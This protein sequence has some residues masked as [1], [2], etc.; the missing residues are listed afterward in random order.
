MDSVA[1]A[2]VLLTAWDSSMSQAR[3]DRESIWHE[4]EVDCRAE[5]V[6]FMASERSHR[7]EDTM[8][9][10]KRLQWRIEDME[11]RNLENAR[12]L[13]LRFVE[14]NRRDVE[15]KTEQLKAISNLAAL[16][17]GFAVVTLT[18]FAIDDSTNSADYS[19]WNEPST[20]V[21]VG[22]YGVLTALVEGLMTI[23]LVTCT[24]ILG[25]I[26]KIGKLYVNEDAEEEFIFECHKFCHNFQEGDQPPCPKRTLEAFWEFRCESSWQRAFVCFSFGV[27]AFVSSLVVIGWVKYRARSVLTAGL[28]IAICG[29]SIL[30]WM[31][32]QYS[33]SKFLQIRR[34]G[35][36]LNHVPTYTISRDGLPFDWQLDELELASKLCSS[37]QELGFFYT[38]YLGGLGGGTMAE[39]VVESF[40]V[41][42]RCILL[43]Y[44]ITS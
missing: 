10:E 5:D 13:W 38:L 40:A 18:Q 39:S 15:E 2:Q 44:G 16:F 9:Q 19:F 4:Y 24:L 35:G 12:V 42:C 32:I 28:F 3:R 30:V 22:L 34:L 1:R 29:I 14:K 17:A 31:A 27:C 8:M 21:L 26:L 43:G 33:W 23:S 6:D 7:R 36:G 37:P 41:F 11:Q 20:V 25:S